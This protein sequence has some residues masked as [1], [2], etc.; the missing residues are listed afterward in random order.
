MDPWLVAGLGNPG[1]R[2]AANRHNIG[3]HVVAE[4]AARHRVT[5]SRHKGARPRPRSPSGPSGSRSSSRSRRR[6]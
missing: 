2:Y 4:L 3:A 6:S 1:S 5:L